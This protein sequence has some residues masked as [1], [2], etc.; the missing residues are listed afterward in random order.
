MKRYLILSILLAGLTTIIGANLY[1]PKPGELSKSIEKEF[2]ISASGTTSISNK[3]GK[4]DIKTWSQ[5]KVKFEISISVEGKNKETTQR[6]LDGITVDFSNS[7]DRVSA[8]TRVENQGSWSRG[9]T[10]M[11]INYTVYLPASNH[12]RVQH[13]H[14]DVAI[15]DMQ[16]GVE[17]NLKHAALAAGNF[18]GNAKIVFAH[19]K[20]RIGSVGDLDADLAHASLSAKNIGN[21]GIKCSHSTLEAESAKNITSSSAHSRINLGT[22][23][24]F[25]SGASSHDQI[26]IQS[27]KE[28]RVHSSHSA[29]RIREDAAKLELD[30]RHGSCYTG[31]GNDFA[32]AD[33]RGEHTNFEL[34]IDRDSKFMMEASS[35]HGG[36]HYPAGMEINYHSENGSGKTVKGY[37]GDKNENA[38]LKASL[39]HGNLKLATN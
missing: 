33:I 31:L 8:E 11:E 14:G 22:I 18:G 27:A 23:S 28:V 16:A 7:S 30:M 32:E 20:G 39:R 5:N 17:L 24:G 29:V 15:A 13:S 6:L 19:G 37:Y 9:Y 4:T 34:I 35:E 2:D 26:S 21:G 12:L 1:Q 38:L 10:K 3:H 25:S 36:I